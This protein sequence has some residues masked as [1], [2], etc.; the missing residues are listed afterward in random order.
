MRYP[1]R[2]L[3]LVAVVV[4]FT[5]WQMARQA[6]GGDPAS[7]GKIAD[8]SGTV[9]PAPGDAAPEQKAEGRFVVH[10]WGTFTNFAGSDGMLV[11]YRPLV[12]DHLPDFV[13]DRFQQSQNPL[14]KVRLYARERMETPITYF[15]TDRPREVRVRVDFPQGLLTEFFPPVAEMG[16]RFQ[17]GKT[18]PLADS[19]LDWGQFR[20]IPQETFDE[21]RDSVRDEESP[22]AP[23]LPEV[24]GDNHYAYARET[25]SAIVEV[26]NPFHF[27]THYEKFLF[28]RGVGKIT[29]PLEFSALG[30]GRFEV[31]NQG[32][33][34]VP[35][36]FLVH[37]ESPASGRVRYAWQPAIQPGGTLYMQ[38]PDEE[39]TV[40]QLAED[41]VRALTDA[42][43]YEKEA[44]AMLKTWRSSWFGEPGTRLLYFVPERL[45]D[46]VLPITIEPR[47]DELVRVLVGRMEVL[48]PEQAA[49]L[50]ATIRQ[51]G[52]CA[53]SQAEPLRS[54]LDRL[55]RFAE[56]A[57]EYVT[58][59][60]AD[61]DNRARLRSLMAEI[62]A[63]R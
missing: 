62:R 27:G 53:T 15:Y 4:L 36:L 56:P 46:E 19:Y 8:V 29:L 42:G 41:M 1:F 49:R 57:L 7:P 44:R 21:M 13:F 14:S 2:S 37:I 17:P 22:P 60:S 39:A 18:V 40:D 30:Q 26:G 38:Q 34:T 35:S 28:Y 45:T 9:D 54:E 23:A 47:P 61:D 43:L 6:P 31:V 33:D 3:A 48:T 20:V 51:L 55:G 16:P 50:S 25:D 52:T 11:D 5:G 24:V 12:D 59:T 32:G 63:A 10:E 58:R